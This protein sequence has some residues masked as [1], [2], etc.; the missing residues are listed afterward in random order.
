MTYRRRR[1]LGGGGGS[2]GGRP[3]ARRSAGDPERPPT[4]EPLSRPRWLRWSAPL[5]VAALLFFGG[6]LAASAW[7][8]P[9]GRAPDAGPLTE[10]PE[11][12][13][14][15]DADARARASDFGLEYRVRSAV[16]HPRAP[17]G[18]VLAQSPI[19][20]QRVRPGAP[21]SVTLSQ[22]PETH[23]L[24]DVS[25]LSER[26]ATIVLE[27]LGYEVAARRSTHPLEAGRAFGTEPSAGAELAVPA[28]VILLV[29]DGPGLAEVPDL[30]G[31]HIDDALQLLEGADLTLGA[32][33]YDPLAADAPGRIVGQYPPGGYALR[34]GDPV[35]V[36]V[37]GDPDRVNRSRRT[38][39]RA[40]PGPQEG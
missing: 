33:S 11:L 25:G 29:S 1:G 8:S 16:A 30:T 14:L 17:E 37:S 26:Q 15:S 31:R 23:T 3:T 5:G 6:Y 27:R 13:G 9:G 10:V 39:E 38:P 18:A 22:G 36:R 4:R 20:G 28:D 32:I 24:P 34:R 19:P 2:G 21:V 7:L 35:E 12:V 40:P